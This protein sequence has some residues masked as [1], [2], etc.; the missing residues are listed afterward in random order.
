MILMYYTF[1]FT[2]IWTVVSIQAAPMATISIAAKKLVSESK[3]MMLLFE[4]SKT[5][6]I[7][8]GMLTFHGH[9]RV[10]VTQITC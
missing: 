4:T 1:P 3:C 7:D 2:C 8:I 9:R 10:W 6:Y 5:D